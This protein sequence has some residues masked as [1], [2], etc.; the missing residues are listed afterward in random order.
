MSILLAYFDNFH[1]PIMIIVSLVIKLP[2]YWNHWMAKCQYSD[3]NLLIG[4]GQLLCQKLL[5]CHGSDLSLFLPF[6]NDIF[7][8]NKVMSSLTTLAL[9]LHDL[10]SKNTGKTTLFKQGNFLPSPNLTKSFQCL[11]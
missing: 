8:S 1:V 2:E 11:L 6:F 7:E 4:R 10:F 5:L 9:I 3:S